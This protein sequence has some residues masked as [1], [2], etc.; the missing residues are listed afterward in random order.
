[1]QVRGGN[2]GIADGLHLPPGPDWCQPAAVVPCAYKPPASRR[3]RMLL[4]PT[5]CTPAANARPASPAAMAAT[6]MPNS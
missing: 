3:Q 1:M 2:V 4:G 5:H 6:L